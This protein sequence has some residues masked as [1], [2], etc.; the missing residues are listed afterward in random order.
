M[1]LHYTKSSLAGI[2]GVTQEMEMTGTVN[3]MSGVDRKMGRIKLSF[4]DKCVPG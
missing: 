1:A 4:I 2:W 3:G